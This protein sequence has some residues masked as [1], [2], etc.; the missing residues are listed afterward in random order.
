MVLDFPE[1]KVGE[2][3]ET[4]IKDNKFYCGLAFSSFSSNCP[5]SHLCKREESGL[6]KIQGAGIFRY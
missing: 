1:P 3:L 5:W 4:D 2:V 6:L